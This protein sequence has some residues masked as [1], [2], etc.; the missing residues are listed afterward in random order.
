MNKKS[1]YAILFEQLYQYYTENGDNDRTW[2]NI[3]KNKKVKEFIAKFLNSS[4]LFS[5]YKDEGKQEIYISI[6]TAFRT[7]DDTSK[8]SLYTWV[9]LLTRQAIFKLIKS[10]LK[11]VSCDYLED[12]K[13]DFYDESYS[14]E[15]QMINEEFIAKEKD[16]KKRIEKLLGGPIEAEIFFR[17]KGLFDYETENIEEISDETCLN[18][19]TIYSIN[20]K[21]N[22]I[23]KE[24]RSSSDNIEELLK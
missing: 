10:K 12:I 3:M 17:K 24:L 18:K 21:N 9:N 23:L 7:Y 15:Q 11:Y 4:S 8:A 19:Q 1:D 14:P 2:Y 20:R 13:I 22:K 5:Q 16:I 6:L